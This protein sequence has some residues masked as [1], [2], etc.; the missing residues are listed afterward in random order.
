MTALNEDELD[1][2]F[3]DFTQ[4]TALKASTLTLQ[5]ARKRRCKRCRLYRQRKRRR[6]KNHR[7]CRKSRAL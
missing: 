6:R 3:E 7:L 1:V 2:A 5:N 4:K